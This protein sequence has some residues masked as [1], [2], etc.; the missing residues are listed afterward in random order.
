MATGDLHYLGQKR[1]W[2]FFD[3]FRVKVYV[4][5]TTLVGKWLPPFGVFRTFRTACGLLDSY[6]SGR[7]PQKPEMDRLR[8]LFLYG[9]TGMEGFCRTLKRLED[10]AVQAFEASGK[11]TQEYEVMHRFKLFGSIFDDIA[12]LVRVDVSDDGPQTAFL[13][14]GAGVVPDSKSARFFGQQF[15]ALSPF[16]PLRWIDRLEELE[17]AKG[18]WILLTECSETSTFSYK[19]RKQAAHQRKNNWREMVVSRHLGG[20]GVSAIQFCP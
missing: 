18:Y 17:G 13:V 3:A 20:R 14:W 9:P 12:V 7:L 10:R 4:T 5:T 15:G 8:D 1:P 16:I 11:S 6:V 19:A 2:S